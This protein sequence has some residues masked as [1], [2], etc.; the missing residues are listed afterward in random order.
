VLTK[1]T[2]S[3]SPKRW[4]SNRIHQACLEAPTIS[5][6]SPRTLQTPRP[7]RS[8]QTPRVTSPHTFTWPKHSAKPCMHLENSWSLR[9]MALKQEE[10]NLKWQEHTLLSLAAMDLQ[11]GK[12]SS[13]E[14]GGH[15]YTPSSSWKSSIVGWTDG[16]P[17]AKR[18]IIRSLIASNIVVEPRNPYNAP[19][20]YIDAQSHHPVLRTPH[21]GG[22]GTV[23]FEYNHRINR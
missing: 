23:W 13:R 2:S 19:T 17:P 1:S 10:E 21:S 22:G 9:K 5:K 12:G 3:P 16:L 7:S 11:N 8:R 14:A 6:S 4:V 15:I 20:L 18:R